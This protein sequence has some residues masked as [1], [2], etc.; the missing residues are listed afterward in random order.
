MSDTPKPPID[1]T[2]WGV[3]TTIGL[4]VLG[5][6]A[7]FLT[8]TGEGIWSASHTLDELQGAITAVHN[9]VIATQLS[10]SGQYLETQTHIDTVQEQLSSNYEKLKDSLGSTQDLIKTRHQIGEDWINELRRENKGRIIVPEPGESGADAPKDPPPPSY[11]FNPAD[12]QP[13]GQNQ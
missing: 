6:I 13:P 1:W 8:W 12:S 4:A 9:E 10:G 3:I 5:G 7:A 2:K 11:S